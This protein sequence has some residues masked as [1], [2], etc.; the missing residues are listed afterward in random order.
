MRVG[1]QPISIELMGGAE[2]APSFT[3]EHV[4]LPDC[5][6]KQALHYMKLIKNQ[7]WFKGVLVLIVLLLHTTIVPDILTPV[8]AWTQKKPARQHLQERKYSHFKV[9]GTLFPPPSP[10]PPSPPW[11]Y[12]L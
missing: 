3:S 6:L 2:P 4:S 1:N 10:P 5:N 12:H 9:L 11:V 8:R 7:N